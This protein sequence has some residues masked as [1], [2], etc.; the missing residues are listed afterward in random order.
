MLMAKTCL[1]AL[2]EA[3][4]TFLHF[5]RIV[6]G[7]GWVGVGGGGLGSLSGFWAEADTME[8]S[9]E[10][11]LLCPANLPELETE[12]LTSWSASPSILCPFPHWGFQ[13]RLLGKKRCLFYS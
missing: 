6:A 8:L 13:Q 3:A 11:S 2:D 5:A 1:P 9:A 12:V 7:K 10:S 4:H